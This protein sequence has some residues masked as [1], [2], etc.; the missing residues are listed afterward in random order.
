MKM[1]PSIEENMLYSMVNPDSIAFFG[2]SNNHASMGT[3]QLNSLLV[4]GF[5]GRVYPIHPKEKTVLGLRAYPTVANLP[6][7]PDLAVIVLPTKIV[8][9]ALKACG[10]KGIR[11]VIIV[12]GGFKEVGDMGIE[13]EDTIKQIAATH[14]IRFLGPNCIGV[15]NTHHWLN[16][17]FM[18][19]TG[20]PGYIG[21]A[22][23]SGSFITQMFDYLS[24]RGLGFSTGF[25]VG[26]EADIDIVDCMHYLDACPHTKVIALY[27]EGIQRGR[28]F[29]EAARKITIRKPIVAYYVGGSKEGKKA[30]FSHTGA[31]AGPDKLYDGVFRQSGVIRAHSIDELFDFCQ[32]LSTLP[33]PS[34]HKIIVQTHSGGPGAVAADAAG[35]SGLELAKLSVE[36]TD[37][38]KPFVPHTGSINNPVDLTYSR[39]PMDFFSTIPDILLSDADVGGMLIYFLVPEATI[40]RGLKTLGVPEESLAKEINQLMDGLCK[41][42][43]ALPHTHKKPVIGYGFSR[44]NDGFVKKMKEMGLPVLMGPDRAARAM[45]ALFG[46]AQLKTKIEKSG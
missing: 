22:S 31:M 35:R 3:S 11:R 26:N 5:K 43:T 25:S 44:K 41:C 9:D 30:G 8:P 19:C 28:A 24:K 27:I 37:K 45:A 14:H 2:A 34:N 4:L 23:Q 39:N 10:K 6:E 36:T 40:K 16:T 46:Y 15:V 29:I 1:K 33:L 21:M 32:V 18:P 42:I 17:T 20:K 13:R 38:L 7:A 12:S